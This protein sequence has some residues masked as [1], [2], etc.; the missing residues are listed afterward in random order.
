MSLQ[1]RDTEDKLQLGAREDNSTLAPYPVDM[2]SFLTL[3]KSTLDATGVPYQSYPR[4]YNPMT[5]VQFTLAHWNQYLASSNEWYRKKFLVKA[6]WLVEHEVL[7]GEDASGWPISIPYPDC[8]TRGPWL[9]ALAQGCGISVLV[10]AYMLTSES[11]FLDAAHRAVRTFERDI[12]D[13]GVCNPLGKDRIFFEEIAIYPATHSLSGFIFALLGLYDYVEL[14]RDPKIEKLIQR[15]LATIH[16]MLREFDA[17]YWTYSDLLQR[18]LASPSLMALQ[19]DLLEALNRYENCDAC[20]T[21]IARWKTYRCQFRSTF[22]YHIASRYTSSFGRLWHR[23]QGALFPRT[24]AD[25]QMTVCVCI[26]DF[27][28]VGGVLTVLQ[29]LAHVMQDK[30][31][32]E[33]LTQHLGPHTE[34]KIIHMFGTRKMTPWFF[35]FVW[36]YVLSG[37]HKL[38]SLMHRGASY[39]LILPQDGVFSGLLAGLAGKLT[40]ARV[41]CIDH[42]NLSFFTPRNSRIYRA[43]RIAMLATKPWPGV[44]RWLARGLLT[45]YWPS[46]HLLARLAA[47]CI[48]HYLI[49]GVAG[50]SVDEGC[51]LIGIQPGRITRYNSMIDINRHVIANAASRTSMRRQQGIPSD[52]IVVALVCRL[53]PEKGLDIALAS[54]YQALSTLPS[55]QRTKVRVVLA[56][57][58]PLRTQIEEEIDRLDLHQNCLLWGELSADEVITLLGIS[59]IFLYTSTRGACM[60]MA[61]LEAMASSCA[62]IAS[63]EPLSNSVLLSEGRGL[64]IPAGDIEQTS[65]ALIRLLNDV[66]LCHSMGKLAR[67]YI[68]LHHSPEIFR[69]SLLRATYWSNL[70]SLLDAETKSN[71]ELMLEAKKLLNRL[72]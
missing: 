70:D 42:G 11:V 28:T 45:F 48:D 65:Q 38:I 15:A 57:E 4:V 26:Q 10:R 22:R 44:V 9:S 46:L 6:R 41:V 16:A 19:I 27:P 1:Y 20:S 55:E 68:S 31:Q 5:I 64:A 8:H 7:I 49:P 50:D 61:V 24:Q 66:E 54:L 56:G 21:I 52:A 14:T 32:I 58:G 17:G 53:A 71:A 37:M 72:G 39:S 30:W 51:K 63:T 25:A 23:V 34:A 47:C 18:H 33:Y 2:S 67:K 3:E 35:P 12:L 40:G 62:V 29:G 69:R 36:L 43:E 13:G 59:D 60:A